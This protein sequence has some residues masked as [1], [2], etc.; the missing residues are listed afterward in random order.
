MFKADNQLNYNTCTTEH[1]INT[2]KINKTKECILNDT[3][4]YHTVI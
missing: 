2:N 3:S 4:I 1:N